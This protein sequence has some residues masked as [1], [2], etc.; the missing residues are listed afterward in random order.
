MNT[1]L[2]EKIELFHR[3]C[4]EN[5]KG[6]YKKPPRSNEWIS[7]IT[8]YKTKRKTPIIFSFGSN[9]HTTPLRVAPKNEV[10]RYRS[11]KMFVRTIWCKPQNTG[12]K[13]DK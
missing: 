8:G 13:I 5:L 12:F 1:D 2:K 7:K 6:V 11:Y 10:S 4:V 9:K 3:Q